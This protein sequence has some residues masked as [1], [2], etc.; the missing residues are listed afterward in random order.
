[1]KRNFKADKLAK[2]FGILPDFPNVKKLRKFQKRK[3]Q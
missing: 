2:Y 3:K 1:M